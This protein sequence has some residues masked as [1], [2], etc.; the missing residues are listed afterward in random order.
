MS[1]GQIIAE[2][3]VN[4]V[5][6]VTSID[7]AF[8][9]PTAPNNY[10]IIEVG[11][12][13]RLAGLAG[14]TVFDL[15]QGAGGAAAATLYTSPANRPTVTAAS[16]NNR[17]VTAMLPDIVVVPAGTRLEVSIAA[18]ETGT[19]TDATLRVLMKRL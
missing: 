6:T 3:R 19:P 17:L 9:L 14:S 8:F 12:W 7:S 10:Q 5:L 2:W 18:V 1:L 4:A 13:R 11:L 16:G 15:L